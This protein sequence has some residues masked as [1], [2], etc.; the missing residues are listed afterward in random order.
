MVTD[1]VTAANSAKQI[2][3]DTKT[4][5]IVQAVI[6]DAPALIPQ[7]QQDIKDV[8]AAL[9]IIKSGWQTSEFWSVVAGM[10]VIG[11]WKAVTGNPPPAD[12]T[13][14]IAGL[15]SVYV[16]AR[17]LIKAKATVAASTATVTSK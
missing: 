15:I 2:I 17:S 1:A 7:I 12:V 14:P 5:G 11:G 9:P 10:L 6:K 13:V 3:A 4:V 8:Q 16:F